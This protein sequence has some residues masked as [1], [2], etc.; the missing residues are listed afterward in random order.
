MAV[1][2]AGLQLGFGWGGKSLSR[3][4]YYTL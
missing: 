2:W 4:C 1:G 3:K